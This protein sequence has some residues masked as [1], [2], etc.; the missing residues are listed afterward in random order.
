MDG[1]DAMDGIAK[2]TFRFKVCEGQELSFLRLNFQLAIWPP[3][4]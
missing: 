4:I 3:P 1:I 2:R